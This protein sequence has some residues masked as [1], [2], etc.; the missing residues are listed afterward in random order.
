M[1]IKQNQNPTII[2]IIIAAV[3]SIG[4]I[5]AFSIPF[6]MIPPLGNLLF[7]GDGIWD[8]PTEVSEYEV[9]K[10]SA[11]S[12]DVEVFRD[13]WGI[14]HIYGYGEEDL[15]FALGYVQAQDRM[16]QMDLVRRLARG[17]LSEIVGPDALD[18][19]KFN[20]LKLEEYWANKSVE[21][22]QASEDPLYKSIYQ[23]LLRYADGI[24]KY[25]ETNQNNKPFEYQFLDVEIAPW[26]I[27]DT[28]VYAKY[29]SEYFT[30]SY[31]DMQRYENMMILG[32]DNY[33]ELYGFPAPYQ[34]PVTPN[35]GEYDDISI[36]SSE[37]NPPSS[38]NTDE[39]KMPSDN[40]EF[41]EPLPMNF[42]SSFLD[43]LQGFPQEIQRMEQEY[44]IGSNN[45]VISGNKTSS[46]KPLLSTD[47]HLGLTLPGMWHE[48]HL[49]D[50]TPGADLNLYAVFVPGVPL[51][52]A[53]HTDYVGW[54][55]SIAAFDLIDWY[56]YNGINDT[57]Y[58]YK[59]EAK[60]YDIMVES[61]PIKGQEPEEYIIKSTV[62]G[63]VFTDLVPMSEDFSENVIACK[64]T[65][66]NITLD[67]LALYGFM[68]A[69]NVYEFDD[70]IKFM[71]LLPLNIAFGD[72]EGNIGIRPNAKVPIRNDTDI[73]SWHPGGGDMPYNGSKGEGEWI[74]YLDFEDRP[75]CINPEQ[76]FLSSANQYIAG[77]D[78]P[79]VEVINDGGAVGYRAR[80]INNL[81]AKATEFTVEDMKTMVLDIYSVRA[82]NFT[83]YLIDALDTLI[84]K[85]DIQKA[86]YNELQ[87]WDYYMDKDLVAP[88]LYHVWIEA[89]LELTFQD[90]QTNMG[91]FSRP[92]YAV[93]EYLTKNNSDSK[94]FDN[95]STPEIENRDDIIL[96]TF[97]IVLEG[98]EEYYGTNNVSAWKWGEVHQIRV[99][100]LMSLPGLGFGPYPISGEAYT[101]NPSYGSNFNN[102]VISTSYSR[103]GAS[104]R[105]IVDFSN[106]N[107]SVSIIP[108]GERGISS[109]VH[110]TDQLEM[111]LRGEFHPQYFDAKDPET[112]QNWANIE[113]IILFKKEGD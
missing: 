17:R 41:V 34:I 66:Y 39:I 21:N 7:P 13:E 89:Y 1:E 60:A 104:E 65:S 15:M 96:D 54:G 73:P 40:S 3:I 105:I 42:I 18:T 4:M 24:N 91:S 14:P 97:N 76:G 37:F 58:E 51:P 22:L 74:D 23:M 85:S 79:N 106:M 19:D 68:H 63:P 6:G 113:S 109:S 56:Y 94:W 93:L 78:Y 88:S 86:A 62:H 101:I 75:Y 53:G 90:E 108:S 29:M 110:Y 98:L 28:L 26:E 57:H 25:I 112:I 31:K 20:I 49:V 77:P 82:G 81:L 102:G 33:T 48:A 111:W 70:A 71:D 87:N 80:R 50:I 35:Y 69:K 95:I 10:D 92:S 11:L 99:D 30:W 103:A 72:V 44:I 36:P 83:P 46:G 84:S 27:V 45:W 32:S 67:F 59:G 9:V 8:V 64:W 16:I 55:E 2:K 52:I 12:H 43:G 38:S 107:N 100:H 47:M 61:I 5:T